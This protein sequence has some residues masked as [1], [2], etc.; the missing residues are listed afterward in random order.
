[1]LTWAATAVLLLGIAQDKP[2]DDHEDLTPDEALEMLKDQQAEHGDIF[3]L[4]FP[5]DLGK[6]VIKL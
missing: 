2:K 6:I 5:F 3:T 1:M 4:N